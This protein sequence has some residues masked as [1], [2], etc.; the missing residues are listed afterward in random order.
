VRRGVGIGVW[1]GLMEWAMGSGAGPPSPV[2][3]A[4]RPDVV[5]VG[6]GNDRV[7]GP[8]KGVERRLTTFASG[9]GRLGLGSSTALRRVDPSSS[10]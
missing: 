2:D 10:V 4:R 6:I 1:L 8:Q 3:G 5:P 9:L 7:S